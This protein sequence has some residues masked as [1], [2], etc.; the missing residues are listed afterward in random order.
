MQICKRQYR[1][2]RCTEF[3]GR[4]GGGVEHPCRHDDDDAGSRFDVN[5]FAVDSLLAVLT[6]YATPVQRVPAVED[7]NFL[8][9]MRR[10]TG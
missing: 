1:R 8:G 9:D 6:P 10:M 4:A 2:S 3:H 7:F 5:H